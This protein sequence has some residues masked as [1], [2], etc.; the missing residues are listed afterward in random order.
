MLVE[1]MSYRQTKQTCF[2][3]WQQEDVDCPS[4][5]CEHMY[6]HIRCI[7]CCDS[8]SWT[9]AVPRSILFAYN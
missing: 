3:A 8:C 9:S 7:D 6:L 2:D 4:V 1:S 5:S